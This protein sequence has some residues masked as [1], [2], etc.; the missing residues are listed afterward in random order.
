MNV[1]KIGIRALLLYLNTDVYNGYT[2]PWFSNTNQKMLSAVIQLDN[3]IS[4]N[5]ELVKHEL[6]HAL[7]LGHTFIEGDIMYGGETSY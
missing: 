5:V 6:G 7:G 3:S 4:D 1:T 2:T